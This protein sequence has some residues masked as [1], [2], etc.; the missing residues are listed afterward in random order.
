MLSR[1]PLL[2][3]AAKAHLELRACGWNDPRADLITSEMKIEV[4]RAPES[5]TRS[6][7]PTDF[8]AIVRS[9]RIPALVANVTAHGGL[10]L[11]AVSQAGLRGYAALVPSSALRDERWENLPDLFELGSLEV[12]RSARGRGVGT[13]LLAAVA[14]SIPLESLHV[15][16]RGLI[17]HWDL[18]WTN[19]LDAAVTARERRA[20]LLHML[21]K[22]GF[23]LWDTTDPEIGAHPL[24]FLAV[25]AGRAA[26]S[27]SLL[28]LA[29]SAYS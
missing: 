17:S 6:V 25:R 13:E 21:A 11:A 7:A 14:S 27:T 2:R 9:E 28:A 8:G 20:Q 15:F 10:V 24:N 5:A 29:E 3:Q 1:A 23:A 26:P 19:E 16:A 12:A 4:W 22:I 18:A